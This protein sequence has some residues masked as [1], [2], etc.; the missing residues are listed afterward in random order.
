[1]N[2]PRSLFRCWARLCGS[3]ATFQVDLIIA[4]SKGN[5]NVS[6]T[7]CTLNVP[8]LWLYPDAPPPKGIRGTFNGLLGGEGRIVTVADLFAPG[9]GP[10]GI[11]SLGDLR[12]AIEEGR[13]YVL[14]H[15]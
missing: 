11:E 5:V 15:S 14:V 9:A 4:G 7:A 13:A 8:V 6:D 2:K 1:M 10:A 12:M 3:G